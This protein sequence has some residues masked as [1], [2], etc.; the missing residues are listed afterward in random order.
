ML[1]RFNW[2]FYA[3]FTGELQHSA[4]L[5]FFV[6][7]TEVCRRGI[8]TLFRV[9]NE[10]CTNVGRFRASR[11]VPL[12]YDMEPPLSPTE[13][14]VVADPTL[15][16][17]D[18][19]EDHVRRPGTWHGGDASPSLHDEGAM[20]TNI[21]AQTSSTPGS[22][23]RRATLTN[24]PIQRGIARVGTI[25]G[26]AHAQDF[27]RKRRPVAPEP[28]SPYD[29]ARTADFSSD[30]EDEEAEV[31]LGA[32][33]LRDHTDEGEHGEDRDMRSQEDAEDVQS[34]QEILR[35]HRSATAQ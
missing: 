23:R 22:L 10:H 5:S 31:D 19:A 27:E 15:P 28:A 12:P 34:A 2:I 16:Q 6:S 17:T 26:Q 21:E 35:R 14:D 13:E 3:L 20:L 18:G 32:P 7:F 9:E 24:T 8:W 25:M 11:D 4:L 1:L 33:A 30:D 29:G